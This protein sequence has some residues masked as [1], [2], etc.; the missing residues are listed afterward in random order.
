M[1]KKATSPLKSTYVLILSALIFLPDPLVSASAQKISTGYCLRLGLRSGIRSNHSGD[2]ISGNTTR[3]SPETTGAQ[4]SLGMSLDRAQA[5][6]P[7]SFAGTFISK[8]VWFLDKPNTYMA[9]ANGNPVILMNNSLAKDPSWSELKSF[10]LHDNTDTLPYVPGSF[11]CAD[12]AMRLHNN[13]EKYGWRCHLVGVQLGAGNG[14]PAGVGHALNAFN[15][16]DYGWVCIDCTAPLHAGNQFSSDKFIP[17]EIGENYVPKSI[18][19]ASNW[20]WGSM[21]KILRVDAF[22]E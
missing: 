22:S 13:A 16:T 17:F 7:R 20:A 19:P 8:L 15:T 11:V 10:L 9:G 1:G 3:V 18:F 6:K 14:Y 2:R 12:F 5:G 21:G 4:S